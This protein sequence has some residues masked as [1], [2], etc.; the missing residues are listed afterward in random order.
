M[1]NLG[2]VWVFFRSGSPYIK[3]LFGSSEFLM[4]EFLEEPKCVNKD[5]VTLSL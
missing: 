2:S 5:I 3:Y 4:E 1:P